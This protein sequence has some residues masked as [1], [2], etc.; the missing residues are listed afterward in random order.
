MFDLFK[1]KYYDRMILEAQQPNQIE[2]AHNRWTQLLGAASALSGLRI[3]NGRVMSIFA[4]DLIDF[5]NMWMITREHARR[6][7]FISPVKALDVQ[8]LIPPRR[9]FAEFP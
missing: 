4:D 9:I 5:Y 1:N 8:H 2:F 6:N 3:P 7:T